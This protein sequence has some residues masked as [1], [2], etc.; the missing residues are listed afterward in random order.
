M[1]RRKDLDDDDD[2]NVR[3]P[4]HVIFAMMCSKELCLD[5]GDN[6]ISIARR[7]RIVDNVM[8]TAREAGFNKVDLLEVNINRGLKIEQ[9]A[10]LCKELVDH[11]GAV[12]YSKAV[13]KA[14]FNLTTFEWQ[15]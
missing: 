7:K 1:S 4:I 6:E 5:S 3:I 10:P 13:E 14:G 9:I 12:A 11:I 8:S 15:T 2:G